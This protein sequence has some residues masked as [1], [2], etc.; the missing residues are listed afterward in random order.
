MK[1]LYN[2]V[3]KEEKIERVAT[4]F[5]FTEGPVWNREEEYLLF[6]DI[7]GNARVKWS[8]KNKIEEVKKPSNKCNGMTYDADGNLMVCEHITSRVVKEYPDGQREVVASHY[9]GKEL[10]SPNDLIIANDGSIYFTD[11][12]YGR[13]AVPGLGREIELSHQGVYRIH[14]K[15]GKL[16]L[17][18]SDFKQPNGLFLSPNEKTLY[19]DDTELY[20]I[21]AFDVKAD[22]TITNGRIFFDK[23]YSDDPKHGAPDG[24]KCDELG[25]IYVTGPGGI[26]IIS[27][28]GEYIGLI[29][30]PEIVGN[31]NWGEKNWD[32]LYIAASTSIYRL[33]MKVKGNKLSYMN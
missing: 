1:K 6:S 4:G 3:E 33:K 8:K 29:E 5:I 13:M 27:P 28:Q 2:L 32:I 11:P 19:V 25:N 18:V 15:R 12:T 9:Q 23:I 17:L 14:P 30:V 31:L 22:G 21:R 26:W 20:H 10:N 16:E 24:M 7:P